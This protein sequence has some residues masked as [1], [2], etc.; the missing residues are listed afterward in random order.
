M[1]IPLFILSSIPRKS[2]FDSTHT[3]THTHTLSIWVFYLLTEQSQTDGSF[4]HTVNSMY[5][6]KHTQLR[7]DAGKFNIFIHT[8]YKTNMNSYKRI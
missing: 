6:G 8:T 4:L 2:S 3:H 1:F 7:E 5:G